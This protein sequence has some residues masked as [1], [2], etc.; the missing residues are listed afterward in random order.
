MTAKPDEVVQASCVL[1]IQFSPERHERAQ[2]GLSQKA[3][4][5]PER[6]WRVYRLPISDFRQ[7]SKKSGG[8]DLDG[9]CHDSSDLVHYQRIVDSDARR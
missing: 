5:E 7:T 6:A 3:I 4:I 1:G 2:V 8:S 9:S